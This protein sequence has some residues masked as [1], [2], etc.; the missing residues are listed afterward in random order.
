MRGF[1]PAGKASAAPVA[2]CFPS[3]GTAGR[4]GPFRALPCPHESPAGF[5]LSL[6]DLA[7]DV[8]GW[9]LLTSHHSE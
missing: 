1:A 4:S 3:P 2:L 8:P 5:N 6:L 9:L 7:W